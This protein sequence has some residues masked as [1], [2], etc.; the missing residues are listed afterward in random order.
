MRFKLPCMFSGFLERGYPQVACGWEGRAVSTS[1]L[2]P[3]EMDVIWT[4]LSPLPAAMQAPR[5]SRLKHEAGWRG[6]RTGAACQ[7]SCL[8][9]ALLLR[10]TEASVWA[11]PF[12]GPCFPIC[13]GRVMVIRSLYF[14][15]PVSSAEFYCVLG[16][17]QQLSLGG[18]VLL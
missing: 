10:R 12:A 9:L 6:V 5:L 13:E 18:S 11:I 3:C 8:A 4:W 14:H 16:D 2:A 1:F 7:E 15:R 17:L